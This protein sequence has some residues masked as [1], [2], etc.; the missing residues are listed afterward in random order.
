MQSKLRIIILKNVSSLIV[1]Y[2]NYMM[3]HHHFL[4]VYELYDGLSCGAESLARDMVHGVVDG[5]PCRSER[6]LWAVFVVWYDVSAWY[7]RDV[8]DRHVVVGDISSHRLWEEHAHAG[9][10][11]R[12]PDT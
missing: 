8:V 2:A 4:L 5:V 10:L 12:L 6:R 3:F 1:L 11:R 7:A 9:S